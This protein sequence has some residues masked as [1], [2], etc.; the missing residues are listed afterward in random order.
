VLNEHYFQID[1]ISYPISASLHFCERRS[2]V[3]EIA[4]VPIGAERIHFETST[5]LSFILR[6]HLVVFAQL[7]RPVREFT[8]L[9]IGAVTVFHESLAQL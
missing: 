4:P 5:F 8:L 2:R 3:D 1:L 9:L 7:L 6:V